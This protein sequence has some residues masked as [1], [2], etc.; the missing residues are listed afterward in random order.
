MVQIPLT[1]A[2]IK[3]LE[4]RLT[5]KD[6]AGGY[7]Y[8]YNVAQKAIANQADGEV[9]DQMLMTAN[10][11][12]AAKSINNIDGSFAS[13]LVSNSMRYAVE[14][15]G[16]KF[17]SRM[18]K[19]ASDRLAHQV[20]AD[21]IHAKGIL[22]IKDVIKRDVQA[23]VKYLGLE[24]WQWAGTL[25]D[26]FPVWGGGLGHNYVEIPGRNFLEQMENYATVFIQNAAAIGM[27]FEKYFGN[28][29]MIIPIVIKIVFE[30]LLVKGVE[31]DISL[32]VVPGGGISNGTA[33]SLDSGG[34]G[35]AGGATSASNGYSTGGGVPV[36]NIERPAA[37]VD[38]SL[39]S[40]GGLNYITPEQIARMKCALENKVDPLILDLGGAGA[41]L[42]NPHVS[43]VHFDMNNDGEKVQTG[44]SSP[45][46]GMVVLD[47]DGN[48][49]IDNVSELMSEYF[50][51][52]LGS[53]DSPS[54]KTF[55][56]AFDALRS[57]DSNK[58]LKFDNQDER[59]GDV[60]VWV[61]ANHD[62]Q[63]RIES[64]GTSE[65]HSLDELSISQIDLNYTRPLA[66]A[67]NGNDIVGVSSF[68]Q[69]GEIKEAVAVNFSTITPDEPSAET[70]KS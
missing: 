47:L 41:K 5:V 56:N 44:W 39:E 25:G 63:S 38:I 60:R 18:Y 16:R 27:I 45:D 21:F 8:L 69:Q 36:T 1:P 28:A 33:G 30:D 65:L 22:P 24:P 61:D 11:L 50:G 68:T 34:S 19:N 46:E 49:K 43:P 54:K 9:R 62:G 14:R 32:P 59:W 31:V 40:V 15:S 10:W 7:H 66:D 17:T 37:N 48:G 12:M 29:S 70:L 42:T 2:D 57:L 6:Y 58:D 20:I 53:R 51:A 13:E 67:R 64:T 55:D 23:A 3:Y 35:G 26:E 52:E 4:R